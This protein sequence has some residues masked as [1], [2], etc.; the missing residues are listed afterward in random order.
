MEI[1]KQV[2]GGELPSVVVANMDSVWAGIVGLMEKC[3]SVEVAS[4]IWKIVKMFGLNK[5][6]VEKLIGMEFG[7][8]GTGNTSSRAEEKT[9]FLYTIYVL[10]RILRSKE[11]PF[12]V[13]DDYSSRFALKGGLQFLAHHHLQHSQDFEPTF[14]SIR[15]LKYLNEATARLLKW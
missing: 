11:V 1:V 9:W 14:V 2:E 6:V 3:K 8:G 7:V 12:A 15:I 13:P 10:K 5:R 4:K